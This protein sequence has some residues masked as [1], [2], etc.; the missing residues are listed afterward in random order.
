LGGWD[1]PS[2]KIVVITQVILDSLIASLVFLAVRSVTGFKLSFAVAL[3]YALNPGAVITCIKIMSESLF[4]F[5]LFGSVV[6][7]G[8]GI[9]KDK[10]SMTGAGGVVLGGAILCRAIALPLP[11]LFAALLFF[12][13][14]IK[15][16]IRHI[17]LIVCC[18]ALIV[19]PWSIRCSVV[20]KNLVLVQGASAIQFYVSSRSD[21]DQ[22]RQAELYDAI[23]GPST[24]DPYGRKVRE[25]KNSA[26]IVESDRLGLSL[27]VENVKADPHR[28][29][30]SRMKS[31][32]HLFLNSFD[33]FSGVNASFGESYRSSEQEPSVNNDMYDDMVLQLADPYSYVDR[34]PLLASGC[35]LFAGL[36]RCRVEKVAFFI[37]NARIKA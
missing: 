6:L 29:L 5:L 19:A 17:S 20:A 24:T 21:L 4:T 12:V 28:Y 15:R 8:F 11:L 13:P 22:K 32:P 2:P 3:L 36:L 18:A 10:L 33:T 7:I 26:E 30:V 1:E 27:A 34:V 9:A 23:F 31:F 16:R 35:T 37:T 14:G 25:A